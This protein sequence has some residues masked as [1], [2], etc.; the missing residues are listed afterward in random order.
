L[1]G[2]RRPITG[3]SPRWLQPG[4]A[5]LPAYV[6][7]G[8]RATAPGP[9]LSLKGKLRSFL[10]EGDERRIADL[11]RRTLD[12]PAGPE[13]AYRAIGSKVLLMVGGFERVSSM[14]SPFDRWGAVTEIMAS[15]WV[16]VVAGR[17]LG[18]V[19]VAERF[20]VTAPYV[21]VDNP[22]S[23]AGGREIYGYAKTM[24]RFEPAEGI[25]DRQSVAAFGGDFGRDE[26]A[27][28]R[29]LLEMSTDE[30]GS[31]EASSPL[32]GPAALLAEL[33]PG[34]FERNAEGEIL[35]PGI[36][37][38]GALLDDLLEGKVRQV[39][40]K[41]FRHAS[42][43]T[44]ACYSSVVEAP[45]EFKRVVMRREPRSW[46]VRISPLDSHPVSQELGLRSQRPSLVLEGELD[47]IC[48]NGTEIGRISAP[49]P[50]TQVV[51]A[52]APTVVVA[53]DGVGVGALVRD[54]ARLVGSE[55]TVLRR[56]K[57]W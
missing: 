37:L 26:G 23:Y 33:A 10:L 3:Q 55:L 27:G 32:E 54:A 29:T 2:I 22:M 14:A 20:G 39:F 56:F 15:L 42:D 53:A 17:D 28:W 24:G 9:F 50:P 4:P 35:L 45:V 40:L 31:A 48:G 21:L 46:D 16:P 49:S 18:D 12:E 44:R 1:T 13:V 25:G 43:G 36:K 38:T 41:Q 8:G 47:M 30:D 57:W 51:P 19:F 7:Y 52:E 5:Q 6:E 34:F 11:V